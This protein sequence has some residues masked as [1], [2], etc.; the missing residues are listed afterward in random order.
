MREAVTQ[1][2]ARK[3]LGPLKRARVDTLILGCTHYPLLTP[4]IQR[5]MGRSVRLIDSAYA[6]AIALKELLEREGLLQPPRAM[7]ASCQFYVSDEPEQFRRV[8]EQFLGQ[9]LD[10]VKRGGVGYEA[11]VWR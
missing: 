1:A 8:G 10:H 11:K 9:R 4:I 5:V 3:Y 2:V 6:T 7:R